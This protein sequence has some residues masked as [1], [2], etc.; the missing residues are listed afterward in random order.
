MNKIK[1]YANGGPDY[2]PM[3]QYEITMDDML[4][5]RIQKL[6]DVVLEHGLLEAIDLSDAAWITIT[7]DDE[8]LPTWIRLVVDDENFQFRWFDGDSE[9]EFSTKEIPIP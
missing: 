3:Q 4:K 9:E 8:P 6:R 2:L 5:I 7:A 1:G